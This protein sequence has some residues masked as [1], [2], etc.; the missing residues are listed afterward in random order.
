VTAT[1]R[2]ANLRQA[3]ALL[4]ATITDDF[5][6]RIRKSGAAYDEFDYIMTALDSIDDALT[7]F[8]DA[9]AL[10]CAA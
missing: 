6:K 3:R 7:Y 8:D 9:V 5:R 10:R 4:D 1:N 2:E